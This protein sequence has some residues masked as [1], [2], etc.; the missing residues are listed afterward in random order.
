MKNERQKKYYTNIWPQRNRTQL[1]KKHGQRQRHRDRD[2][3]T[4]TQ[5]QR[6]TD[7]D[8]VTEKLLREGA[9]KPT[10]NQYK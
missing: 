6:H 7:K 10:S 5:R 4:E 2:R 1:L 9:Q 8:R 3:D